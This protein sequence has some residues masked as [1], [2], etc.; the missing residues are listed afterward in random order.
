MVNEI[1]V[2][3]DHIPQEV[4]Q[5]QVQVQV[6]KASQAVYTYY[7]YRTI[8]VK[9]IHLGIDVVVFKDDDPVKENRDAAAVERI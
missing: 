8:L 5:V 2:T 3:C 9:D 4:D 7:V 1:S 6:D